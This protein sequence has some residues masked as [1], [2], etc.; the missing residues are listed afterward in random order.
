MMLEFDDDENDADIVEAQKAAAKMNLKNDNSS[1]KQN[2]KIQHKEMQKAL[3]AATSFDFHPSKPSR[4]LSIC[5]IELADSRLCANP[6][7]IN[8]FDS[9]VMNDRIA[10]QPSFWL[11]HR[12]AYRLT[13]PMIYSF[14]GTRPVF[15]STTTTA[16]M[17]K[18]NGMMARPVC[19]RA[20]IKIG[21]WND[22]WW[23][24]AT[25]AIPSLVGMM[26]TPRYGVDAGSY[27]SRGGG[28]GFAKEFYE[29]YLF[30][31]EATNREKHTKKI[32]LIGKGNINSTEF[33]LKRMI[34]SGSLSF[35]LTA[36]AARIDISIHY[37]SHYLHV[38]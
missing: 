26:A 30:H 16:T 34:I 29:N 14:C 9:M 25:E 32:T 15:I 20:K 13:G 10:F 38:D 8:S 6:L 17:T 35:L 33:Y 37:L 12:I 19:C 2:N 24:K 22:D 31:C 23:D 5:F 18:L 4:F 21:S 11:S 27:R 28:A 1:N 7:G 3:K 36:N